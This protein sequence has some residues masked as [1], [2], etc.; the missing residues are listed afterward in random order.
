VAEVATGNYHTCARKTDGTLWCWG[1]ADS[2]QIGDGTTAAASCGS[3]PC[4]PLPV[5]V[6]TLGSSVVEVAAG[7]YHTCAR[8]ADGTVW[9]W[10]DNFFSQLGTGTNLGSQVCE[11]R[12]NPCEPSPVRATAV[13]TD[14]AQIALGYAHS[15]A[16]KTD[17]TAWCWGGNYLGQ[18]G[19]GTLNGTHECAKVAC[20][21]TA[22]ALPCP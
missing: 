7:W 9:C 11:S 19:D 14:A 18:L 2:G 4:H 3:I 8:K 16:V 22:V 10:G 6:T 21:P 15:C 12:Q 17:G 20:N 5:Q 1:L 13:G